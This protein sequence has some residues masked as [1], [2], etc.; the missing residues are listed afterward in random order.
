MHA[1]VSDQT[2]F[3][4]CKSKLDS[5]GI[6]VWQQL[7]SL[8]N[9]IIQGNAEESTLWS[10][11]ETEEP[12][13]D[14]SM[15]ENTLASVARSIFDRFDVHGGQFVEAEKVPQLLRELSK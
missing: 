15:D 14:S 8:V 10:N 11:G 9:P 6:V 2:K 7:W 12:L 1:T 3:E 5:E 4:K 13:V